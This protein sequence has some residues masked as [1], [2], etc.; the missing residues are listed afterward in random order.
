MRKR[1]LAPG[2]ELIDFCR[3][4]GLRMKINEVTRPN[5]EGGTIID[6]ILTNCNIVKS[7]GTLD[8]MLS[9][10]YPIYA[11]R[12]QERVTKVTITRQ[13]RSYRHYHIDELQP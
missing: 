13:G 7:A 4:T 12:K 5:P 8:I 2:R 9:D 3:E 11:E 1:T 10:H 6:H